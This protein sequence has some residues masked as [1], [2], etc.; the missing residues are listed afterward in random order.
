[1]INVLIIGAGAISDSHI[2]GYKAL[3]SRTII[4]AVADPDIGQANQKITK[5]GLR[6]K[7]YKDYHEA[8][9]ENDIDLVSICTPPALHASIS[10]CCSN[11]GVNV[12]VE[13]PMAQSL[14]QC[15]E[16]IQAAQ[17]NGTII[18]SVAQL[19]FNDASYKLKKILDMGI[20][21][22]LLHAQVNAFYWRGKNYYDLDWRGLWGKEGGGCTLNHAVHYIDLLLW[23]VGCPSEV[24]A[25]MTNQFH[26]NSEVEDLS[27][28]I[29]KYED[30]TL[31]QITSS[32][33]HHGEKQA[34]YFQTERA[35]ISLPFEV[36]CCKALENG[37]P[38]P[39]TDLEREIDGF[40]QDIPSREYTGHTGQIENV[41][42]AMEGRE[43]LLIPGESG[44][45]TLEVI[46][47]IYKSSIMNTPVILPL[48]DSDDFYT[49]EGL[50]KRAPR[51]FK[52]TKSISRF[53]T[54]IINVGGG[55]LD[56]KVSDS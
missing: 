14:K 49:I 3:Q 42:Q 38:E 32:L 54:N 35:G 27:T 45:Q 44:R 43:A 9:N 8:L 4:I 20:S 6:A 33:I 31:A 30:S 22:R 16:M 50:I 11:A 24:S 36:H 17:K 34:M 41:L 21:G 53:E 51:F 19:R 39:D 18:S 12:I 40:Y 46:T 15:D 25:Y 5:F 52:K 28:A 48:Q 10:I 1:M 13:K 29:L 2:E 26:D 37:F 23:M 7:A 55:D 56:G 47:A